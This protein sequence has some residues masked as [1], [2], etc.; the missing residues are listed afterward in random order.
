RARAWRFVP[1]AVTLC[2]A[3]VAVSRAQPA[4]P[5]RAAPPR[6]TP[7]PS[8][9]DAAPAAPTAVP[10]PRAPPPPRRILPAPPS[11]ATKLDWRWPKFSAAQFGIA[12]AQGALA[13]ASVA[14]PGMDNFKGKNPFDDAARDALRVPGR[15]GSLWA[16]DFSDVGLV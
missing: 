10:A 4:P 15:E 3:V 13:V 11:L 9:K 7:E 12:L 14:I 2:L 5:P 16:R 1:L 8:P 6:A